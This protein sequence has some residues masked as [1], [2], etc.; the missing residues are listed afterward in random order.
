M[1]SCSRFSLS[2]YLVVLLICLFTGPPAQ[3]GNGGVNA[4][5]ELDDEGN[6]LTRIQ[7]G[8]LDVRFEP[9]PID[10]YARFKEDL[11][12]KTGFEYLGYY[13]TMFHSGTRGRPNLNGQFHGIAGWTPFHE[14]PNAGTAIFYYMHIGQESDNSA[15]QLTSSLGL[16]SGINDSQ[17]DVDLYRFVG[18]YQPL[19][20]EKF[21][22]YAGQFQ[23]RDIYDSGDYMSDDTR[24]FISEIMSGNPSA[25]LPV[26]GLGAALTF[27]LSDHWSVGGGFSDANARANELWNFDSF[28]KGDHATMA[29]LNFRPEISGL[30]KGNYQLNAYNVDGT[31]NEASS[32]GWSL[33]LEQE[34]GDRFL[35]SLKYNRADERRGATKQSAAAAAM[36][37]GVG[38]W[39]NDLVG[40]GAGW[41]DPTN[42]AHRDEYVVEGFWRMQVTPG[43][44]ITPNVQLWLNP[45][46]STVSDIEAVFSLRATV[47]F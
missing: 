22:L 25:T 6:R 3:G 43:I 32:Q 44:Q 17:G 5:S 19:L 20:D 2:P 36:L 28:S 33:T 34:I 7:E 1:K 9:A 40:V 15:A 38:K 21:E 42:S 29:Y 31:Q 45:S 23:L 37:R 8:A 30:G 10:D 11:A 46:R 18:W 16:T 35:A 41:G 26:A 14:S 39:A 4:P 47:D 12:E 27:N 13:T 24:N